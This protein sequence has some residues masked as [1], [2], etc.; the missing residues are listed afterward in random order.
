MTDL[1]S[2]P[3]RTDDK[4][5]TTTTRRKAIKVAAASAIIAG[6]AFAGYRTLEGDAQTTPN[7]VVGEPAPPL[8]G[9]E[10]DGGDVALADFRGSVVMIN[11]WA[12]WCHPCRAEYPVLKKAATALGPRGLTVLGINTQDEIDN[13]R[14]FLKEL[15][16]KAYPSIRDPN[17][18]IAVAWGTSGVP[19][20][21]LV[22]PEGR[23]R[24]RLVGEVTAQWVSD[25][26][27]PM[28]DG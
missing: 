14:D 16:G 17:G 6:G 21:F 19:E 27:V 20:T 9:P 23:V 8:E 25:N 28:L 5:T 4:S 12:S 3:T 24:E 26:V 11:V 18:H 7:L 10:L 22:D 15:G 2:E 1:E 13:A